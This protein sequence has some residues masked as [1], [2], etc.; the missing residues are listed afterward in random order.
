MFLLPHLPFQPKL[1][2]LT[3]QA[4]ESLPSLAVFS[5]TNRCVPAKLFLNKWICFLPPEQTWGVF[6]WVFLLNKAKHLAVCHFS[7]LLYT[8]HLWRWV[9]FRKTDWYISCLFSARCT[10]N[11]LCAFIHYPALCTCFRGKTTPTHC[12]AFL[13]DV[14]LL[15][16]FPNRQKHTCLIDGHKITILLLYLIVN[17]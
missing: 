4:T 5:V 14:V 3:V 9:F 2:R 11:N 17:T 6:L 8:S 15:F 16:Y 13:K 1:S 12:S 10:T 7:T